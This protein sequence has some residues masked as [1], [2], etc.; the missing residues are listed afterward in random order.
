MLRQGGRVSEVCG[1]Q[2]G[3]SF[4]SG[5]AVSYVFEVSGLFHVYTDPLWGGLL[6]GFPGAEKETDL[7]A[8]VDLGRS[9]DPL[10]RDHSPKMAVVWTLG[11]V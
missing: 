8:G 7:A 10:F 4:I 6:D 1:G 2:S 3:L 11:I 9:L 5:V